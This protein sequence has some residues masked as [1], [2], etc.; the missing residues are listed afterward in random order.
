MTYY[1]LMFFIAYAFKGHVH[2]FAGRVKGVSHLFC[3]TSA[4]SKYFCPLQIYFFDSL[5]YLFN[6][7]T[8]FCEERNQIFFSKT[9]MT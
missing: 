8:T 6:G 1:S 5:P 4:I 2:V 7:V 3:S 9:Q